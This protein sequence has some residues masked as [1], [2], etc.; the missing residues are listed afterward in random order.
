MSVVVYASPI[1]TAALRTALTP[2]Y[3]IIVADSWRQLELAIRSKP[4]S[5]VI[6]DPTRE[7][8]AGV[9]EAERLIKKYSS[10]PFL[11]YVGVNAESVKA[12]ARL[13]RVGLQ[14]V[15]LFACDDRAEQIR[16]KVDAVSVSPLANVFLGELRTHLAKLPCATAQS[17]ENLFQVPHRYSGV[18]DLANAAATTLSGLYRSFRA[19]GL[20]SPK[21]FLIAARVLR[22]YKYLLEPEFS[23]ENV[24]AKACYT[25]S[26]AFVRHVRQIFGVC[27]SS[28]RDPFACDKAL[29]QLLEWLVEDQSSVIDLQRNGSELDFLSLS[30]FE[31][32]MS[33][34]MPRLSQA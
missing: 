7:E 17:V 24:A 19:A 12:V 9:S 6:V 13:A 2:G 27:P 33:A 14:D 25:S 21:R 22:G 1:Q 28:L 26:R 32:E 18:C 11:A 31:G 5:V 16:L 10:V 29:A 30:A 15:L 23:V 3:R 34:D 8:S 20:S 4:V